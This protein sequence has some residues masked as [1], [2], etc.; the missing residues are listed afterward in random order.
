MS[1]ILPLVEVA[2]DPFTSGA[3]YGEATRQLAQRHLGLV[4]EGAAKQGIDEGHLASR[5]REFRKYVERQAPAL[6]DEVRGIA[7]GAAMG[8]DEAWLLQ[9]RTEAL[10]PH[11]A[12]EC[13]LFG[14]EGEATASQTTLAGQNGDLPTD[15]RDVLVLVRRTPTVG[16]RHLTL[17]PAGQLAWHGMNEAGLAVFANFLYSKEIAIGIPRYF[18]SR[19]ALDTTSVDEALRALHDVKGASARHLLVADERGVAGVE[20]GPGFFEVQHSSAGLLAHSNHYVYF[21]GSDRETADDSYLED[22]RTRLQ[23]MSSLLGRSHGALTVESTMN[24]LRDRASLPHPIS[25]ETG[26]STR[27]WS[28]VAS[29]IADIQARRLWVAIGPPHRSIYRPYDV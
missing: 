28:T 9:L 15:Y 4:L 7:D 19:I 17:T 2:G 18:Y 5:S 1:H 16:P 29:T 27:G 21:D 26:D 20:M 12:P 24:I 25:L 13:T 8:L 23:Q 3:N 10:A 14:A 22:S 6:A 11:L